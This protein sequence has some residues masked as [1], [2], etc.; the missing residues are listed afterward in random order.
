MK[1]TY[2]CTTYLCRNRVDRR[3]CVRMDPCN[4][5][6]IYVRLRREV[7][8]RTSHDFEADGR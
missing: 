7:V 5:L 3:C 4:V 2:R 1:E 6:L 8:R